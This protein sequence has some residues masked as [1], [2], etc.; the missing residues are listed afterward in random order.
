MLRSKA[1]TEIGRRKARPVCDV[2]YSHTL[3]WPSLN[4]KCLLFIFILLR[5]CPIIR[6]AA[7]V[8]GW[9]W[10][11]ETHCFRCACFSM[12]MESYTH[13]I[14]Y[15]FATQHTQSLHTAHTHKNKST[16]IHSAYINFKIKKKLRAPN[17]QS[18]NA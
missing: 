12:T 7:A 16:S 3:L 11:W 6:F 14:S 8:T 2:A 4:S 17:K 1:A 9:P 15:T 10:G 5:L 13:C 18:N